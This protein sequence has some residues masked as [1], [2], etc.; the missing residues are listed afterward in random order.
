[1]MGTSMN[2]D[3]FVRA[4]RTLRG[5]AEQ[6]SVQAYLSPIER[7]TLLPVVIEDLYSALEKLQL[8]EE[9]LRRLSEGMA[10][11]TKDSGSLAGY[12][13]QLFELAP[14]AYLV[15]DP[16]GVIVEANQAAISLL[17]TPPGAVV[18]SGLQMYVPSDERAN[19]EASL[20]Q[21]RHSEGTQQWRVV[22]CPPATPRLDVALR[23]SG[24]RDEHGRLHSLRWLLREISP[25]RLP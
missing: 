10:G 25:Q 23:V 13:Q 17:R 2:I 15:T 7:G 1:M 22:L 18:G 20:H 21:L 9:E 24:A 6:I 16:D 19:F 4:V 8:A 11:L 12:Y 5:H 14:D 3:E